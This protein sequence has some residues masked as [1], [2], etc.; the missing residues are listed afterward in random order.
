MLP[1]QIDHILGDVL[2]LSIKLTSIN[3][4]YVYMLI[5]FVTLINSV[6]INIE[7]CHV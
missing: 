3:N 5:N 6:H 4:L 7:T 2:V 1:T